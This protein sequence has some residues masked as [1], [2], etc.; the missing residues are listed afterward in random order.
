MINAVK[1]CF[2]KYADFNGRSR[3]SEY[4][5][6]SLFNALIELALTITVVLSILSTIYSLVVLIPG[7]AVLVRRLH[8]TG[9]SGWWI[10]ICLIPLIGS[11]ILLVFLCQDSQKEANNWGESPKYSSFTDLD[12]YGKE[13]A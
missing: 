1:A 5:F 8:D 12:S 13:Q 9:R 7:L 6:F 11:I 2:Q 10:L 4:W 3:R